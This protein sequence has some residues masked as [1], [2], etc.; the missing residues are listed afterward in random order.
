VVIDTGLAFWAQW[1]IMT[2]IGRLLLAAFFFWPG[3]ALADQQLSGEDAAYI[4]WA[5]QLWG[6]KHG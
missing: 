5:Q 6:K 2:S 3:Q 1:A 4:D